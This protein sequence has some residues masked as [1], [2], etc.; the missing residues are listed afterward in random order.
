ME[1]QF[2]GSRDAYFV[3]TCDGSC[4]NAAAYLKNLCA[5][6]RFRF[7]GLAPVF[8]PENYVAMLPTPGE[9]ECRAKVERAGPRVLAFAEQIRTGAVLEEVPV[10]LKDRLQ[11]GL[12]NPLFYALYVRDK[13]FKVSEGCV[14]CGKC[15][16]RCPLNNIEY[17]D[18]RPVWKGNCTH[19]M[20]CIAAVPRRQSSTNPNPGGGTTPISA[21]TNKCRLRGRGCAA[22]PPPFHKLTALTGGRSR[23]KTRLCPEALGPLGL[24]E[25][26]QHKFVAHGQGALDQ[27]AVGG[28]K[29]QLLG[30]AHTGKL[31]LQPE[32]LV[33]QAA[34]IEK[35]LELSLI[36]I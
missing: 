36:H 32:G 11:S 28:E 19:C 12:V 24:T 18:G 27:H 26:H 35:A 5:R 23:R 16:G 20:V 15:A 29:V 9:A 25:A 13:G 8:M 1:A 33:E 3:L 22:S 21:P 7:C 6:K 4:G 10:T 30:L 2:K 14:S 17:A 31:V 34:G